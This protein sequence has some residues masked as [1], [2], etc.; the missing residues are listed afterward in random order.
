MEKDV[1]MFVVF[2][3]WLA[4]WL[5]VSWRC[6][7]ELRQGPP[8]L[9]GAFVGSIGMTYCACFICVVPFL[10]IFLG[11]ELGILGSAGVD[12]VAGCFLAFAWLHERGKFL[13]LQ[14]G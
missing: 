6:V 10:L 13:A 5:L 2:S 7:K 4:T 9:M 12:I 1:V 11:F 3:P 8:R 14:I